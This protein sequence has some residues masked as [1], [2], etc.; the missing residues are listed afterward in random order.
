MKKESPSGQAGKGRSG[1]ELQVW[2]CE[3]K[4][5]PGLVGQTPKSIRTSSCCTEGAWSSE[6]RPFRLHVIHQV[7]YKERDFQMCSPFQLWAHLLSSSWA[8]ELDQPPANIYVE[9][10][11]DSTRSV[12]IF[13]ISFTVYT[14]CHLLLFAGKERK[15][16]KKMGWSEQREMTWEFYLKKLA[17]ETWN[18]SPGWTGRQKTFWVCWWCFVY[19][20]CFTIS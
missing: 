1:R 4:T 7:S 19:S 12:D 15:I 8:E 11:G 2:R 9:L 3:G 14:A 18:L 20:A 10:F 6:L 5:R 16:L 17:S 13:I